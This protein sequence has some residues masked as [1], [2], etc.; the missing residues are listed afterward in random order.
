VDAFDADVLIY[1]ATP[2][3]QLGQKIESLLRVSDASDAL[4]ADTFGTGSV[5]LLPEL[6]SKPTREQDLHTLDRLSKIIGRLT[7]YRTDLPTSQLAVTLGAKYKLRAAGAIH[8]ATAVI[9]G[10]DRFITNN[11]RDFPRSISEIQIMY[12][13]DLPDVATT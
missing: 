2:E 7:L 6:L 8:L 4:D 13:S 1:A 12:P 3:H 9:V 11:A 10:A 5:L